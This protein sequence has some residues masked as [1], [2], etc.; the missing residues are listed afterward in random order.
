MRIPMKRFCFGVFLTAMYTSSLRA[1]DQQISFN[2]DVRPILSDACFHCH[3]P[4]D[5]Q[6]QAGLRFDERDSAIAEA[7]SG[8]TPIVPGNIS[9]SKLIKRITSDDESVVMPPRDSGKS[10]SP[11]QIET[12]KRWISEGAKYEGHW[13]FQKVIRPSVPKVTDDSRNSV[14]AA[15][16]NPIDRFIKSRLDRVNLQSSSPATRET[17]I[18]RVSLDLTGL[19]PTPIGSECL[20]Y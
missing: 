1:E 19:P 20:H 5:Q 14:F 2:R 7:E 6:R 4:D 8:E 3:G 18:R 11:D 10:I 17:L 9:A 16:K 12:L 15:S 13:A